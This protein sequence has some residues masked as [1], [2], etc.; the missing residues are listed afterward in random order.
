[1][2]TIQ[3][4]QASDLAIPAST[5]WYLS[6]LGQFQGMQE[7]FTRQ[8]PQRLKVLREH[9]MIESAVL[10][11]KNWGGWNVMDAGLRPI[12]ARF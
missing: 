5:A 4:F 12:G 9:A 2:N 7:L 3:L 6:D 8:T 1:M 11:S 10:N